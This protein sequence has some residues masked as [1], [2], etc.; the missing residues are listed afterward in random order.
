[1]KKGDPLK[2]LA[3]DRKKE[4]DKINKIGD[5]YLVMYMFPYTETALG[6]AEI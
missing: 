2:T 1:M 5:I 6:P 3:I 4:V